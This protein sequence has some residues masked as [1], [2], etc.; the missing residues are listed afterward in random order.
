MVINRFC[1]A[2]ASAKLRRSLL[3]ATL[4]DGFMRRFMV[5][6]P[7]SLIYVAFSYKQM[8]GWSF[9]LLVDNRARVSLFVN[10]RYRNRGV[11][12]ALVAEVLKSF[13]AITVTAWDDTT[14]HLYL[15]LRRKYPGRIHVLDWYRNKPWY[16]Q[17]VHVP[18]GR[19]A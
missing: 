9:V 13:V 1:L 14:W 7:E 18:H 16:E 2:N 8:M 4:P 6:Y 17:V 11:A 19:S 12:R 15:K 5:A 10:R 3:H